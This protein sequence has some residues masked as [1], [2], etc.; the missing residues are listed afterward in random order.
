VGSDYTEGLKGIGAVLALEILSEFPAA[1]GLSDFAAWWRSQSDK[2]TPSPSSPSTEFRKK[3][4]CCK[5]KKNIF[6]YLIRLENAK[7]KIIFLFD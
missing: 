2:K 6:F 1:E 5:R 4:V 3:M 7:E